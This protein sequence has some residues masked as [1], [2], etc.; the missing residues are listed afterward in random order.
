MSELVTAQLDLR[1]APTKARQAVDE[2]RRIISIAARMNRWR[3][4]EAAI[5]ALIRYQQQIVEWWD[6][7]VPVGKPNRA[8]GFLSAAEAEQRI[9]M[10]Q[11]AISRFRSGI[12]D[13][14]AYRVRLIRRA[15]REG[16]L[17]ADS[18]DP[19]SLRPTPG[20]DGPDFWPTPVTLVDA[21]VS[22]VLPVLPSGTIWEPAC[23]DGRLVRAIEQAGRQ[24]YATD[25]H[26]QDDDAPVDFLDC[27]PPVDMT[28][29]VTNPPYNNSDAFIDRCLTLLDDRAIAGFALLLRHDHLQAQSRVDAFNRATCE[30][31]CNWRPIWI[32]GTEGQ[33]RWSFHWIVWT[34]K[35]R[36]A[37]RYLAAS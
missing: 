9:A 7:H 14:D 16:G 33:P 5:D 25:L 19:S 32:D 21:C 34:D 28:C 20:R 30:I 27:I 36:R 18:E 4:M 37:P 26:P 31:H 6:D 12:A 24:V 29:V 15:R 2:A 13:I 17:E 10:R 23:G 1:I 22:H 8:P 35:P 11:Q 3:E